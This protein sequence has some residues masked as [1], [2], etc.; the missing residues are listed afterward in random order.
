MINGEWYD[1]PPAY[2]GETQQIPTVPQ[3]ITAQRRETRDY[4]TIGLAAIAAYIAL[5]S[6][7]I[8]GQSERTIQLASPAPAAPA[9]VIEDNSWNWN[10]CGVCTDGNAASH[11]E[12]RQP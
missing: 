6:F 11:F 8:I 2:T 10:V 1:E 7:G 12:I 3:S 5:H 4:L 9:I